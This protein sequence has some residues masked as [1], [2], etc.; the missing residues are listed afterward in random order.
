MEQNFRSTVFGLCKKCDSHPK[1]KEIRELIHNMSVMVS[2]EDDST[3][4]RPT[5][6]D[7][8]YISSHNRIQFLGYLITDESVDVINRQ[9][10]FQVTPLNSEERYIIEMAHRTISSFI[11][12]CLSE[13][14]VLYPKAY[15]LINPYFEYKEPAMRTDATALFYNEELKDCVDAFK[16]CRDSSEA[17]KIYR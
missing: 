9:P 16:N 12:V 4:P 17:K 7:F 8:S 10:P 13:L 2:K 11:E 14:K 3:V 6:G 5:H 15:T 1:S